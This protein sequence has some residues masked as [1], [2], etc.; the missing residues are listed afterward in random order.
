[1]TF[2]EILKKDYILLDGGFG[3]ELIKKGLLPHEDTASA[4]FT[5]PDWVEQIHS[6]YIAAGSN[7]ILADTFGANRMK[8]EN[9]LKNHSRKPAVC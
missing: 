7:V 2:T 9:S 8:L 1:M 6:D 5:H 4:V 3:T